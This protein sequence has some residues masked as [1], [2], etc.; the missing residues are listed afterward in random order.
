MSICLCTFPSLAARGG[1]LVTW[2]LISLF[3]E[4]SIPIS[5][6]LSARQCSVCAGL[7]QMQGIAWGLQLCTR[8]TEENGPLQ[9]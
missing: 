5:C 4:P 3:P 6:P 2:C 9:R 8:H 1:C 7:V